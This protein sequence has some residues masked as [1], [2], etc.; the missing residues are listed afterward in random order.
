VVTTTAGEC[1]RIL[2]EYLA[3]L[4][5]YGEGGEKTPEVYLIMGARLVDFSR[6][7]SSEQILSL[8]R[9]ELAGENPET[10]VIGIFVLKSKK[11]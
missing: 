11:S 4:G 10:P 3:Q 2:K 1:E 9:I 5:E 8:Q 6:L 7:V